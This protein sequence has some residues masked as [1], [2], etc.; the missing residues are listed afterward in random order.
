MYNGQKKFARKIFEIENMPFAA[1]RDGG[2]L[3]KTRKRASSSRPEQWSLLLRHAT[4]RA[5]EEKFGSF[6]GHMEVLKSHALEEGEEEEEEDGEREEE[7]EAEEEEKA[8]KKAKR[9]HFWGE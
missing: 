3:T 9:S 4:L 2:V 6:G 5:L 1:R 7:E 8:A